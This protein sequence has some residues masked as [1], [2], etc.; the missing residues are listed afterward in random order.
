MSR[1][2]PLARTTKM[3]MRFESHGM[4]SPAISCEK[5]LRK[6]RVVPPAKGVLQQHG[7]TKTLRR[8]QLRSTNGW[9]VAQAVII[10]I[11]M[12][13]P[14]VMLTML[15]ATHMPARMHRRTA[16]DSCS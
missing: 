11:V 1:K 14:M 13:V 7:K 10:A 3:A 8:L 9:R 2:E 12:V 15:M 4:S 6:R 5:A 16:Q